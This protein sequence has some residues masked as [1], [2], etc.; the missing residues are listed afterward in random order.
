MHIKTQTFY[1]FIFS[2]DEVITK[3]ISELKI[4][5]Y[6]RDEKQKEL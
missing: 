3:I 5:N 4:F 1:Y 2:L 6:P